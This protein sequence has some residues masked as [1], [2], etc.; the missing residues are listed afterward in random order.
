MST[1]F[2]CEIPESERVAPE[3]DAAE[4]TAPVSDRA[5]TAALFPAPLTVFEE[6]M[7]LDDS[8]TY[9]MD[10]FRRLR[11]SGRL[12]VDALRRAVERAVARHPLFSCR[13]EKR[14]QRYFWVPT[15]EPLAFDVVRREKISANFDASKSTA[16]PFFA[17]VR[18][19]RLTDEPGLRTTIVYDDASADVVFQSHHC[20]TDGVGSGLFLR[21]VLCEYAFLV[22]GATNET[23]L[24]KVEPEILRR[25]GNFGLTLKTYLRNGYYTTKSTFRFLFSKP[26]PFCE[27]PRFA[28]E[29]F[30]RELGRNAASNFAADASAP[31][32]R[33]RIDLLETSLTADE[34]RRCFQAAKENGATVN[35]WALARF[36]EALDRRRRLCGVPVRGV[37]RIAVP[38]DMRRA[39]HRD[40]P[41]CNVVTMAFLDVSARTRRDPARLLRE[42]RRQT[43]EI[44]R[45]AQKYFLD[46]VLKTGRFLASS[47]GR[48]LSFFLKSSHCRATAT[49]SNLG[50][51][52]LD[53][54]LPRTTDGRVRIGDDLTLDSDE[55]FAPIRAGSIVSV[56]ASTYAERLRFGLRYDPQFLSPQEA[57][58][59]LDDLKTAC[60]STPND[61]KRTD[62][63]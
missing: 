18:P 63:A 29:D 26:R 62:F 51:T 17:D 37:D 50:R 8:P 6:Y 23:R 56:A 9:P 41:A 14:S 19:L 58:E 30:S 32:V 44:K 59:F 54:P 39:E 35:D 47:I 3:T 55:V 28:P 16:A 22:D 49:F 42:I 15:A 33:A 48:D 52:L 43:T 12:D 2:S 60:V 11:F 46:L 20:A 61:V 21:D 10:I 53:V 1:A 24:P 27:K 25:R 40:S 45:R 5:P 38:V 36:C 4:Q 57:A 7:L 31:T 13:V 34:T